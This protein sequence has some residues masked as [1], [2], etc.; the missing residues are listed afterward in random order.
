[1]GDEKEKKEEKHVGLDQAISNIWQIERTA[2][3]LLA[4]ITKDAPKKEVEEVE[5]TQPTL[6][7]ILD[8]GPARIKEACDEAFKALEEIR[9]VLF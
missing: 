7:G 6:I 1:M 8:H 4:D 9:T 5:K 2:N 3:R